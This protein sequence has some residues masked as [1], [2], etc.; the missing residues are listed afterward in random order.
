MT[1]KEKLEEAYSTISLLQEIVMST[2]KENDDMR[3]LLKWV[4]QAKMSKN[5]N[6]LPS[7]PE[8]KKVLRMP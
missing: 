5:Y 3:E 2:R 7:M 1:D 8:L 6:V 4:V